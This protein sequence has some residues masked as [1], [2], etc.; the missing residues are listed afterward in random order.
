M[1]VPMACLLK[2]RLWLFDCRRI[3]GLITFD[4]PVA[5]TGQHGSRLPRRSWYLGQA[6]QKAEIGE[7]ER[8][9][10]SEQRA[11]LGGG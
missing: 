7:R 10:S 3:H 5:A 11:G 2:H 6:P 1:V 9:W 4:A 8:E